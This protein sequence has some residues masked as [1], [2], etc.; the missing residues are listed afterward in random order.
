MKADR[1]LVYILLLYLCVC[2]SGFQQREEEALVRFV[3]T[4]IYRKKDA[5][6][7]EDGGEDFI[8]TIKENISVLQPLSNR[9]TS[10]AFD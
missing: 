1:R 5:I 7:S 8:Q 4:H 10:D 6:L 9:V 2:V 3:H